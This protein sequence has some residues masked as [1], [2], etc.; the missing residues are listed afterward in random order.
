LVWRA[1]EYTE[2]IILGRN[3]FTLHTP[4]SYKHMPTVL[5][6]AAVWFFLI[7]LYSFD[8]EPENRMQCNIPEELK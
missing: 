3:E 7:V 1:K 2:P 5:V 6:I 4:I 8:V